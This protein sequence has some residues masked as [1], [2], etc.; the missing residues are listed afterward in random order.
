MFS[1]TTLKNGVS[2]LDADARIVCY[3]AVHKSYMGG[4][5]VWLVLVP[6]GIP[7]FFLWL[8]RR[9]KVPQM[10]A[11]ISDNAWLRE[12]IK[13]AWAE[14]LVQPA[15]SGR[16]TV[17]SITTPH[18]EAL[19]AFFM[20]DV[21]AEDGAEILAGTRPPHEHTL[22]VEHNQSL[23]GQLTAAVS[24]AFHHATNNTRKLQS[25]RM[26][27]INAVAAKVEGV[28]ASSRRTMALTSVLTYM[29]SS[30][31]V[32]VPALRWELPDELE[33]ASLAERAP[34]AC[35]HAS[36]LRC[37]DV[38]ELM[39]TALGDLSFLFAGYRLDCWCARTRDSPP[40]CGAC[41]TL[42]AVLT[43]P[44]LGLRRYWEVVELIRKLMLTS[45]L[46]L[47]APG[48]AGQVVVGLLVAFFTLLA[49]LHFAPYAERNLNLVGQ[50]VQANLFFVLFVG[51]LLKLDIDGE[52][53]S[54]F[55]AGIVSTLCVIPVALPVALAAYTRFVGGGIAARGIVAG[56]QF[57]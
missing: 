28:D 57:S 33:A 23:W 38:P 7:A 36:G 10:V 32:V 27:I 2:Y 11:L 16:L 20:H 53:D 34:D 42:R 18:L 54:R 41:L 22:D 6:V 45:I 44:S 49:T 3:D 56:G 31:L 43:P 1:C 51:L 25:K 9:F 48:S 21:S 39:R 13:L 14:G 15:D 29:R 35:L 47:I 30:G 37:A 50:A 26:T 5:A 46:A 24:H 19:Y 55:F 17:D 8:L 12:S 4:A 40:A 52:A